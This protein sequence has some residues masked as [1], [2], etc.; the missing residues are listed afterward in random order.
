M[1]LIVL[2]VVVFFVT[3]CDHVSYINMPNAG[4]CNCIGIKTSNLPYRY[5]SDL[6]NQGQTINYCIGL[7]GLKLTPAL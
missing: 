5:V 4:K 6:S 3:P 1:F 2:L 7:E